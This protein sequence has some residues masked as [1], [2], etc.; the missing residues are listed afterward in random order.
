MMRDKIMGKYVMIDGGV[1]TSL[2][3]KTDDKKPVWTFNFTHPELVKELA[4]EMV[5]AGAE[6]VLANTFS[7]NRPSVEHENFDHSVT[8][9]V[10][11]AMELCKEAVA[12]R[13]KCALGIGPLT[14]MIEPFGNI[15]KEEAAEYFREMIEAGVN[16]GCDTIYLQTF[17]DLE[18]LKIAAAEA[19]KFDKPL[20]CSM[21]FTK[22]NPKKGG[23]T[24]FGNT[25]KQIAEELAQFNPVAIGLNCSSGPDEALPIIKEFSEVTDLPLI[26][27]PNAGM[28]SAEGGS[29]FDYNTFAEDVAKASEYP[30][31]T[32]FGGCCG[33]NAK[34]IAALKA[35]LSEK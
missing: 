22:Y 4:N 33:A 10:T 29:E 3:E 1:G 32:Y 7:A 17:M 24:M 8:E 25:P 9:I 20:Y 5:E 26:F 12:G 19:A 30:G 28:P 21:S 27:K 35:K 34:Y 15:K 14:G 23:R 2:W 18:M 16:A 13:A 31:V 6:I 11:K